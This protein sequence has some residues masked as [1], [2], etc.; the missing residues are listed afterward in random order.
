MSIVNETETEEARRLRIREEGRL[1][2]VHVSSSF[3]QELIC[4]KGCTVKRVDP[5]PG[6]LGNGVMV[7]L[8]DPKAEPLEEG[9]FIPEVDIVMTRHPDGSVTSRVDRL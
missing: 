2:R 1:V 8:H 5:A 9:T 3:F 7:T 6:F 4:P